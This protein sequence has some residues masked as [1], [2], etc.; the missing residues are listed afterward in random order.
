MVLKSVIKRSCKRHFKD[1]VTN[2][3]ETDKDNYNLDN[4]NPEFDIDGFH[5]TGGSPCI[6]AGTFQNAPDN[7]IDGD[8]RPQGLGYDIGADEYVFNIFDILD[9]FDDCVAIVVSPLFN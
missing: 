4:V 3:E 6:D 8:S 9:F 7:D 1:L 5:L 2:I